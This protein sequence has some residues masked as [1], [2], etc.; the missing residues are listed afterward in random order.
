M[1]SA[2]LTVLFFGFLLGLKHAT[3]ADHVVAVSTL[4]EEHRDVWR[5]LW[6]GVS[7]GLGHTTPLLILGLLVL[8]FKAA[9]LDQYEEIAWI[10]ELGVGIM[11]VGLGLQV[12]WGFRKGRLHVH[13]HDHDEKPH[14]HVHG[15]HV[16][17]TVQPVTGPVSSART[18]VFRVKSYLIGMVHGMAGTAAV[19]LLL[20]PKIE[21]LWIGLGY[22]LVFGLGTMISMA[23]I[24][25][26]I[27]IPFTISRNVGF[28]SK[29]I[30]GLAGAIS[31]ILGLVI[32]LDFGFGHSLTLF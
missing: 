4:V 15:T 23:A 3:D 26:L 30:T 25:V 12:F 16:R 31:L 32:I 18:P 6:I 17:G 1:D 24:T 14:L 28:W 29:G 20:L 22:L 9:V 10:L 21:G 27:G 2:P 5:G 19:M 7:W 13:Q 11:L 8:I